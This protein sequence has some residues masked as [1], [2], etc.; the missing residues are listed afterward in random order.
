MKHP[1]YLVQTREQQQEKIEQEFYA[2]LNK[3][4]YGKNLEI[5]GNCVKLKF[6]PK[7]TQR[8]QMMHNNA[9][10][11]FKWPSVI[12]F[13]EVKSYNTFEFFRLK[14]KKQCLINQHN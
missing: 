11:Q 12:N 9:K 4:S 8:D 7:I 13:H 3:V 2:I 14:L 10:K 5:V 1:F 6:F